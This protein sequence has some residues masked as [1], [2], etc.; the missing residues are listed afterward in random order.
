MS[1]N[2]NY[3][4]MG[5][6]GDMSWLKNGNQGNNQDPT[7]D[8]ANAFN[9]ELKNLWGGFDSLNLENLN[10]GSFGSSGFGDMFQMGNSSGNI[11][12]SLSGLTGGSGMMGSLGGMMGGSGM[13]GSLGGMMGGSGMMGSFDDMLGGITGDSENSMLGGLSG[14]GSMGSMGSMSGMMG[15]SGMMGS[16]DDMLGGITGDS[17][18]SMLGGLSGL[19]SMGSMGS[20]SGMMGGSGMM[21]SLG[22]MMGGNSTGG[23]DIGSMISGFMSMIMGFFSSMMSMF[24]GGNAS[25]GM[26][27]SNMFGGLTGDATVDGSTENADEIDPDNPEV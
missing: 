13:M 20:M 14:L 8:D 25:G 18:N 11:F 2:F 10:F 12:G 22:G 15:G 9:N 17:E 24:T 3:G 4:G 7:T 5:G 16:F 23:F 27:F 26:D 1:F 19:G 6:Y 21:G